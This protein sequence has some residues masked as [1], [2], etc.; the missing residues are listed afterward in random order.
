M[1][2]KPLWVDDKPPVSWTLLVTL[3]PANKKVVPQYAIQISGGWAL[4]QG[5]DNETGRN[6]TDH[7][8]LSRFNQGGEL[9]ETRVQKYGGH[10]DRA[11]PV[12]GQLVTKVKGVWAKVTF[13]SA[14][15]WK[16]TTTPAS[17]SV[18]PRSGRS[19]QGETRLPGGR[20]A[21]LY[22]ESMKGGA[23][24]DPK[25]FPAVL[26]IIEGSQVVRSLDLDH[27]ARD[28]KGMPIGGRYEPEGVSTAT[29]GGVDYLTVGFSVGRLGNTT[30]NVYGCP[31][32][33]LI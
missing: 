26:D 16:G 27:V 3:V 28:D 1:S 8:I 17:C 31:L 6:T 33:A 18:K 20:W 9:L 13:G 23:E 32:A 2:V 19:F 24:R 5:Q 21:R 30:M 15:S 4:T 22:G 14:W 29:V 25:H 7:L 10:G 12:G 11:Y